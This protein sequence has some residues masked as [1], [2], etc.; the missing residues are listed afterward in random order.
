[1]DALLVGDRTRLKQL[2]G[3]A[4]LVTYR[5]VRT[6][7][8]APARLGWDRPL[9]TA[10]DL[11][12]PVQIDIEHERVHVV[13]AVDATAGSIDWVNAL[14]PE[15]RLAPPFGPLELHTGAH[16]AAGSVYDEHGAPLL[17]F[18]AE[19]PGGWGNA[20]QVHLSTVISAATHTTSAPQP[21]DRASS[22]VGRVAG[23]SV[24]ALVRVFQH[25]LP[26]PLEMA[27]VVTAVDPSRERLIWDAPL[28][29][30]LD[31]GQP[32]GFEVLEL[33][34]TVSERGRVREA[35]RGL[36]LSPFSPRF[37]PAVVA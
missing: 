30:A 10:Y 29:T 31:L 16:A 34:L 18:D 6:I 24:G 3:G 4:D 19:S 21:P 32:I 26:T 1:V 7:D 14:E 2:V 28:D 27:R 9:D 17:R 12:S 33:A 13:A 15:F 37:L 11:T 8:A 5:T 20:L 35:M 22:L 23:F 25:V 36:S